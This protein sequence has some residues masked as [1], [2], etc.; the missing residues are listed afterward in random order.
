MNS[1]SDL[2]PLRSGKKSGALFAFSMRQV[3]LLTFLNLIDFK[4]YIFSPKNFLAA[5]PTLAFQNGK[6][7]D[8]RKK[9]FQNSYP[10]WGSNLLS[11]DH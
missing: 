10:E 2:N 1:K 6:P 7:F 9:K 5:L 3:V 4:I 11:P 8:Y